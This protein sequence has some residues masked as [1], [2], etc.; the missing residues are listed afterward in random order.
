MYVPGNLQLISLCYNRS[1]LI[2]TKARPPDSQLNVSVET[3]GDKFPSAGL[4]A[5][6]LS[7]KHIIRVLK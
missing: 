3:G 1:M 2:S 6:V 5:V 4:G 7:Y